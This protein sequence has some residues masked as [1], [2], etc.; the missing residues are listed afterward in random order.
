MHQGA[1]TLY[2]E[3]PPVWN[4]STRRQWTNNITTAMDPG[5]EYMPAIMKHEFGHTAGLHHSPSTDDI[6]GPFIINDGTVVK[7]QLSSYD[8]AAMR[9]IY[10]GRN[11]H[12]D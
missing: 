4:E 3:H 1:Q 12:T 11:S 9:V 6:M 8:I 2:F 10:S 5:F 7:T